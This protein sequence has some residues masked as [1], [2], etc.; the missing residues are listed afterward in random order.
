MKKIH[1]VC[2][3]NVYRSRMAEAYTKSLNY[4]ESDKVSSSGIQAILALNGEV[5]PVAVD[6][7]EKDGISNLLSPTWRQTTQSMLDDS[8]VVVILS[9]SLRND[10][11]SSFILDDFK[12]IVWDV[13]DVDGVYDLIKE[14]VDHLLAEFS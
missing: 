8:E 3:G 13:P 7:L 4:S 10:M 6:E 9:M 14:K 1:Y 5:D 12:V 2:R 11:Q